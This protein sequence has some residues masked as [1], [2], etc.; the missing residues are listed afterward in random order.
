MVLNR[1]IKIMSYDCID[2]VIYNVVTPKKKLEV[3]SQAFLATND[4]L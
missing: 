4:I 1:D 2:L 3:I